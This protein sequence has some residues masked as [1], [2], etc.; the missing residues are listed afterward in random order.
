ME[1]APPSS[2]SPSSCT[3]GG[4]TVS[5]PILY[6]IF[7]VSGVSALLYQLV[8]QRSLLTIFGSNV[9][10]VAIVVSSF[11]VGLGIGSLFG[12]WLSE[13]RGLALLLT[14]SLVEA[15]IGIYGLLSLSIFHHAGAALSGGGLWQTGGAC[16]LLLLVPTLFMGATLPLLVTHHVRAA[17][18]VGESISWLYF[19]N[20]LGAAMGC[21]L[22]AGFAFRVLG[23]RDTVT[24]A[25]CLNGVAALLMFFNWL[26]EKRALT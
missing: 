14:F 1:S 22:A 24:L 26:R 10:S 7:F 11:M 9:E 16:F 2:S 17:G 25:A 6:A 18:N 19:V 5:R 23:L 4:Y 21:L 13:K 3:P 8:W 15:V 12:G 20:T